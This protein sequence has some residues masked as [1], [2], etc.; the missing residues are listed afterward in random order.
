MRGDDGWGFLGG[1][2][3]GRSGVL[4]RRHAI[5]RHTKTQYGQIQRERQREKEIERKGKDG[6]R[7]NWMEYYMAEMDF[8]EMLF[9]LSFL[10]I[11]SQLFIATSTLFLYTLAME[12]GFLNSNTLMALACENIA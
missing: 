12:K 1:R 3:V 9:L 6:N 11:F 7:R 4:Q 10:S 5:E 2:A 8:W